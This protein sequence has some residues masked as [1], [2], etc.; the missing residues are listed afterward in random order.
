MDAAVIPLNL[1]EFSLSCIN[2]KPNLDLY[3]NFQPST[4]YAR[5]MFLPDSQ[6]HWTAT[7]RSL[8]DAAAL[9]QLC[10]PQAVILVAQV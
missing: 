9:R 4:K 10:H 7:S 6:A 1:V 8:T 2:L 3:K 5:N